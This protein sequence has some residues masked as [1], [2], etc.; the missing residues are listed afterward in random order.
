MNPELAKFLEEAKDWARLETSV[1]GVAVVKMPAN[2]GYPE[3]LSVE[4]NPTAKRRGIFIR[5]HDELEILSKVLGSEEV[6]KLVKTVTQV[7]P[8]AKKTGILEI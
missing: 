2:K 1:E 4:V 5:D 7:N 6:S 8:E 3:R